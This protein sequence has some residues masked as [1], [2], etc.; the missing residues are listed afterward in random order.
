MINLSKKIIFLLLLINPLLSFGI[1][2]SPAILNPGADGTLNDN[3]IYAGINWQFGVKASFNAILG[4]KSTHTSSGGNIT[5][6]DFNVSIPIDKEYFRD[7]KLKAEYVNGNITGQGNVGVGYIFG[8]DKF[9]GTIGYSLPYVKLGTDYVFQDGFEPYLQINTLDKYK[10]P[11]SSESYYSCSD[12][13]YPYY[14]ASFSG[15][16][17]ICLTTNPSG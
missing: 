8:R 14:Y 16:T 10:K 5:G 12:P 6:G 2:F 4:L 11:A 7:V 1:A 9:L 17:N 3:K 15:F 13:I